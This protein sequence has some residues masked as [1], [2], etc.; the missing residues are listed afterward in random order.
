MKHKKNKGGEKPKI[1][2]MEI[3]SDDFIGW[4]G[5]IFIC[6]VFWDF[7]CLICFVIWWGVVLLCCFWF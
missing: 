1:R 2:S 7:F 5:F 6:F 4:F 3:N